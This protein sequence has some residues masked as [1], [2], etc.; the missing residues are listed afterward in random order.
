MKLKTEEKM[1]KQ[2]IYISGKIT[3]QLDCAKRIFDY[4]EKRLK[5]R[6][7]KVLNHF[8]FKN[9]HD[10]SWESYMKV[11]VVE[12]MKADEIWMLPDWQR[13]KGAKVE[14]KIAQEV[15]ICIRYIVN[16]ELI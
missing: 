7:L 14:H 8:N 4:A 3:G 5:A 13:S 1:S 16:V 12:L 15:G 11:C 9:D 2:T 6:G 10:K